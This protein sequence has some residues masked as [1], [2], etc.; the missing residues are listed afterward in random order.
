[1]QISNYSSGFQGRLFLILGDEKKIEILERKKDFRHL[2]G[3]VHLKDIFCV[4][5]PFPLSN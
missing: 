1:M 4:K 3:V 5:T 2:R